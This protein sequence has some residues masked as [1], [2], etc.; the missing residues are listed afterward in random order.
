MSSEG[1]PESGRNP[2]CD[3]GRGS[4]IPPRGAKEGD[5]IEAR[6]GEDSACRKDCRPSGVGGT[7]SA[8]FSEKDLSK[9]GVWIVRPAGR[10]RPVFG[11]I[12]TGDGGAERWVL[13]VDSMTEAVAIGGLDCDGEGTRKLRFFKLRAR[14][15]LELERA[16]FGELKSRVLSADIMDIGVTSRGR[17]GGVNLGYERG[18]A[19]GDSGEELGDISPPEG[20]SKGEIV[21]VGE[22]S[23]EVEVIDEMLSRW[24]L[25]DGSRR[26]VDEVFTG[27]WAGT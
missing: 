21:V 26:R 7:R 20:E 6:E 18:M 13:E 23:V 16:M 12:W 17:T 8:F 11:A 9:A 2:W 5:V 15:P 4:C 22:D 10:R 25:G 19:E 14:L 24:G 27:I 3:I 1:V